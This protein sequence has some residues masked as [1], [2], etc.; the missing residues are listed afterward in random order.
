MLKSSYHVA[1]AG[2]D[3]PGLILGALAAKNGYRVLVLGHGGKDNVYD[4]EGY[5]FVRRPNLLWGFDDSHPIREVFRELA[6]GPEMRNRPKTMTPT[7][8]VVMP[9]AR[10]EVSHMKGILE[11]EV[12]RE[13]P[14][15]RDEFMEF[16]RRAAE[17]EACIEPLLKDCPNV[18]P[19]TLREWWQWRKY[20]KAVSP[21]LS[22]G[23]SDAMAPFADTPALAAFLSAPVTAM[24]GIT[25]PRR[26]P[27]A[28]IRLLNHLLRGLYHVDWGMDAL[29]SLFVEKIRGN[30]G[31]VRLADHVDTLL[32]RHGRV[33]E[34]E[35]RARDESLGVG[36]MV[37][38]TDLAPLLDLIPQG[39]ARR[40]YR[41]RVD[42]IEP[43]HWLVTLNVGAKREV[44]P[45]GMARTAFVV[46]DPNRPLEG[47]NFLIVQ[48]DPAMEPEDV[49]DPERTT[50]SVSGLFPAVRFSGKPSEIETFSHELLAGLRGLMPFVDRHMT[51]IS[52]S[53]IGTNPKTGQPE[54][55]RAGL[56]PIYPDPVRRGLDLITW[57]VRTGYNNLL[58]LG[59]AASGALGFEGAFMSAFMALSLLK[60][61]VQ[62][63][64]EAG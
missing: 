45:E 47:S 44:I 48:Q 3:L 63:K 6:L 4:V 40:R 61:K 26:H 18:P 9:N 22:D 50:I 24:A 51:A 23:S 15:R 64:V 16:L 11:Q 17:A 43:S 10:L 55:D 33:R 21:L 14:D 20:R 2:T 59:D 29:K 12:L 56:V 32:V 60:K 30:S 8:S 52:C 35:V 62:L 34:I 46:N 37:A 42:A 28:F 41:Q 27:L 58:F 5:R 36:V 19:G 54:V 53:A 31:D 25:E 1:I 7:C 57:P 38:A 13:F 39:S 49:E